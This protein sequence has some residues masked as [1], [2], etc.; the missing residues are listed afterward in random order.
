MWKGLTGVDFREE[1]NKPHGELVALKNKAL[2][3][4]PI[5]ENV[6]LE[7]STSSNSEGGSLSNVI[8]NGKS[9]L[10]KAAAIHYGSNLAQQALSMTSQAA[11]IISKGKTLVKMSKY[12]TP[13][14][15]ASHY[16]ASTGGEMIAKGITMMNTASTVGNL[17]KF[18][19]IVGTAVD[20]VLD[21]RRDNRIDKLEQLDLKREDKVKSLEL[22]V[23]KVIDMGQRLERDK[24][25][26]NDRM[27]KHDDLFIKQSEFNEKVRQ[28]IMDELDVIIEEPD[29]LSFKD[30][31]NS[32][33]DETK[34]M[35]DWVK[36]DNERRDKRFEEWKDEQLRI[37][38]EEQS[39]RIK[40]INENKIGTPEFWA[41]LKLRMTFNGSYFKI[42]LVLGSTS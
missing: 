41:G 5:G 29:E 3:L 14:G 22:I 24:E 10:G 27:E 40:E 8:V 16:A 26:I 30:V 13:L 25:M 36:E 34:R 42:G 33:V 17:G 1:Y 38:R 4:E 21:I 35:K 18:I 20:V 9:S 6:I 37:H 39:Q 31:V 2:G 19:P 11:P 12:A 32:M 23:G 28:V 7:K 15:I